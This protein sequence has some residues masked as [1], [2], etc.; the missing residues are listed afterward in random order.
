MGSLNWGQLR[1]LIVDD[2]AFFRRIV[3]TV[4]STVGVADVVETGSSREALERLRTG[5]FDLVLLDYVMAPEDGL[6]LTRRLRDEATSPAPT[7]PIVMVSGHLAP[8]DVRA[9]LE[10]GVNAVVGKPISAR[11]LLRTVKRTLSEPVVFIRTDTYFG[12]AHDR[13]V[14]APSGPEEGGAP[15]IIDAPEG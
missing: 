5:A 2:N 1:V 8:S 6:S 13:R 11:D 4:L 14:P 9:A 3:R 10:T 15:P 12:P 7:I